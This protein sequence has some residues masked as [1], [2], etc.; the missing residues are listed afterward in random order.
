MPVDKNNYLAAGLL[1]LLQGEF[2]LPVDFFL[3]LVAQPLPLQQL[4]SL[5]LSHLA[6]EPAFSQQSQA[7]SP[8]LPH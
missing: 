1:Q 5:H 7:Q 4:H 3:P 8:F 2:V 6:Q